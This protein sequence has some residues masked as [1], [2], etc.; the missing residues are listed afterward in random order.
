M[1]V[2]RSLLFLF[3][4]RIVSITAAAFFSSLLLFLSLVDGGR[5]H[6][7]ASSI[8]LGVTFP[9]LTLSLSFLSVVGI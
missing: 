2:L 9:S 1:E 6:H 5:K 7:D 8:L 3:L 4:T